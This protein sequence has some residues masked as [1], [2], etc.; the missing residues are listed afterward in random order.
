[1][2]HPDSAAAL[3]GRVIGALSCHLADF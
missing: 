3:I 2:V 1:M